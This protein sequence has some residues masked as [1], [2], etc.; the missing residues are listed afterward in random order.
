METEATLPQMRRL[1]NPRTVL[2]QENRMSTQRIELP[3]STHEML[4]TSLVPKN[5]FPNETVKEDN[6][7]LMPD[8]FEIRRTAFFGK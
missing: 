2:R 1:A 4:M 5:P 3:N 7:R 8:E 6:E